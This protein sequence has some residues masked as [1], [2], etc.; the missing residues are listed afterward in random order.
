MLLFPLRH[1]RRAAEA[2][3]L[4]TRRAKKV[5]V[6]VAE[7]E[8]S[9]AAVAIPVNTHGELKPYTCAAS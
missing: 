8:Q 7:E 2:L 9:K 3:R 1:Q 5:V 6:I 4:A